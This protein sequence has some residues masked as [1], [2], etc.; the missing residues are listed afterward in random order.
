MRNRENSQVID[1]GSPVGISSLQR[2]GEDFCKKYILNWE[3]K[4]EGLMDDENCVD[5]NDQLAYATRE[6]PIIDQ[7]TSPL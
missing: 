1:E 5:E 7:Q 4:I 2:G 6:K 3:W